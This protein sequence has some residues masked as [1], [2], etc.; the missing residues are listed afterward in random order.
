MPKDWSQLGK[1]IVDLSTGE[2]EPEQI[3][4]KDPAAVALGKKGGSKGGKSRASKLTAS[5][6]K[7]IARKAAR[8]RWGRFKV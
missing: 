3:P 6:R 1:S 7:E 5:E 2:V 8:A 4:E